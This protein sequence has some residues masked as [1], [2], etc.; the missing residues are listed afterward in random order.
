LRNDTYCGDWF[1]RRF[2]PI[3]CEPRDITSEQ[4]RLCLKNKTLSFIGD[5]QIRDL[6]VAVGL[7]LLG[8]TVETA[9]DKKF[10]KKGDKNF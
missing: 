6:G 2:R 1:G 7:F 3:G 9:S 8:E 10:D 5:S 4:A